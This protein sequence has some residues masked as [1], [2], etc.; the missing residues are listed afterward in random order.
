MP[1]WFLKSIEINGGFL[2]GVSI[3]FPRGLT[4]VIGPRGS[5]KS[6]LAEALRYGVGGLSRG[7]NSALIQANLGTS[8]ISITTAPQIGELGY[9]IRRAFKQPA[10]LVTSEGKSIESL[11]LDRGTFLP[12]DAYN[13]QEIEGIANETLGEKRRALLDELREDSLREINLDLAEARRA[14]EGNADGVSACRRLIRDL[15]EQIEEIGDA[16]ARLAALPPS[17]GGAGSNELVRL[18]QELQATES[19]IRD[20]DDISGRLEAMRTSAI[21]FSEE[22]KRR[23][24]KPSI[25]EAS[26]NKQIISTVWDSVTGLSAFHA[27]QVNQFNLKV[28]EILSIVGLNR[29]EL[30]SIKASQ[31]AAVSNL[32]Q[33][34]SAVGQAIREKTMAEQ[35]V[36]KLTNLETRRSAEQVRL[37]ELLESRQKLKGNFLLK[38]EKIS[39]LREAVASELQ[40]KIGECVRL[41]VFRHADNLAYKEIL[42]H[43]LR[44]ARVRNH[45]EI[46]GSLMQMRPEQLAQIIQDNDLEELE[47]VASFGK[48]RSCRILESFR[49][50]LNPLELEVIQIDDRVSIELNVSNAGASHFKD[51]SEL[52]Q[53]QKCTAL[54]PLL[55][56]R[57]DTPL[58]IDQPEDNLDNY[59]IF[60]TVV[61]SIQRLRESR[62]M[63]FIT[64]NANIP[65]LGDADLV[66][67]MN[68][69]G[70]KG[71]VQKAGSLDE[72]RDE[73]IDLLEGGKKAFGERTRRYGKF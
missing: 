37:S 34:N 66:V 40:R 5:G 45:D 57:R 33:E 65:V 10:G 14:L 1:N 46:L 32:Q 35:A 50:T 43:G 22:Q 53:G 24:A 36:E 31:S 13:S 72:C 48:E 25:R 27:S 12:L 38:R 52:S 58:V 23:F 63:I 69:D 16:R 28:E 8:L 29:A 51:A 56:S 20:V 2:P 64:H 30:E 60:E 59:F 21:R 62:Q 67:V 70:K 47:A 4:C 42:L 41:R 71:Y 7:S 49:Q 19:D 54:L 15:T 11:D 68:S 44:G 26:T 55:L 6:T 39:E 17:P 73:I 9:T 18:T 3:Q 61:D